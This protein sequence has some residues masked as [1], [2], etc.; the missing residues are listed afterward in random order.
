[1]AVLARDPVTPSPLGIPGT[2]KVIGRGSPY[3]PLAGGLAI[4]GEPS[5]G[6]LGITGEPMNGGLEITGE[7]SAGE[8]GITGEPMTLA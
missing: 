5:A 7:P 4:T 3:K 1:M 2:A 8:L 6:E